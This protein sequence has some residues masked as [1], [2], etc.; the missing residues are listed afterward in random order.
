MTTEQQA[1][2]V[3]TIGELFGQKK[4]ANITIENARFWGRP[5]FSGDLDRFK[6]S[7]RKFTVL[8]PNELADDLRNL[9]WPVKSSLKT[10]TG[11]NQDG[12]PIWQWD[13]IDS[14]SVLTGLSPDQEVVSSL[15]VK[16]DMSP[17]KD[18]AGKG[19]KVWITTAKGV[20]PE[21]LTSRTAGLLDRSRI[22]E[23]DMELRAWEYDPEEEP[24][25][26]SARLVEVVGVVQLNRIHE[27]YGRLGAAPGQTVVNINEPQDSRP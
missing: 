23:L 2:T 15:K 27:K 26:Y 20:P 12:T 7:S 5:N 22:I 6:D 11:T 16:V 19:S 9:G 14:I 21:Q 25:K 4:V 24:G 10:Q 17:E 1:P 8:I 13:K 3:I 18:I